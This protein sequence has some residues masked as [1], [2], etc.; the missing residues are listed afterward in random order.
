MLSRIHYEFP[1]DQREKICES[2]AVNLKKQ[3]FANSSPL[4][5]REKNGFL[6]SH[7]TSGVLLISSLKQPYFLLLTKYKKIL[8]QKFFFLTVVIDGMKVCNSR[9]RGPKEIVF[10]SLISQLLSSGQHDPIFHR[11]KINHHTPLMLLVVDIN[12]YKVI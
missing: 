1:G 4:C 5:I 8:S 7:E 12:K 11:C 6:N 2:N 3:N 10:R 9:I